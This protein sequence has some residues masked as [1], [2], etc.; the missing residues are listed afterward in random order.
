LTT[1]AIKKT[2]QSKNNPVIL[3]KRRN[4]GQFGHTACPVCCRYAFPDA[5]GRVK[6]YLHNP[7]DEEMSNGTTHKKG[8]ILFLPYD[9][10]SRVV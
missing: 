3:P 7:T 6:D 1:S 10:I 4:G 5:S 9:I 2:V 8:L